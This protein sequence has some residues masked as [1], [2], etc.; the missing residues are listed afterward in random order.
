MK[1]S[2]GLV[3]FAAVTAAAAGCAGVNAQAEIDGALPVASEHS[4]LSAPRLKK[5]VS[6]S[7]FDALQTMASYTSPMHQWNAPR[8]VLILD[9]SK[10]HDLEVLRGIKASDVFEIRV[11]GDMDAGVL[12]GELEVRVTTLGGRTRVR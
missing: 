8:V 1:A 11:A 4:T 9:G 10:S 12:P 5:L 3:V 7:A 6:L 2:L